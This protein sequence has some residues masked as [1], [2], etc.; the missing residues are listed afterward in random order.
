MDERIRQMKQYLRP[1]IFPRD[2][3]FMLTGVLSIVLTIAFSVS[4]MIR[5]LETGVFTS[6]TWEGLVVLL[7]LTFASFSEGIYKNIKFGIQLRK[8]EQNGDMYDILRDFESAEPM[9]DG[10]VMMGTKYAFGKNCGTAI[11]YANIERIYEYVHSTNGIRDQKIIQVKMLN[12][13]TH[14]LCY[15]KVYKKTVEKEMAII[16]TVLERNPAVKIGAR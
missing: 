14:N 10:K 3:I 5:Y 15:L 2:L 7:V 8:W 9:Y 12:R 11:A 6:G 13:K 1:R 16:Q 4:T